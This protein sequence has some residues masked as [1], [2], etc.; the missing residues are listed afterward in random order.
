MILIRYGEIWLKGDNRPLFEKLLADNIRQALNG[1]DFKLARGDGRYYVRDYDEKNESE[2]AKKIEKVFGIHSFSL[3][4]EILKDF[5]VI[6][7][8][9]TEQVLEIAKNTGKRSFKIFCKRSDKRF[10]VGSQGVCMEVGGDVLEAA[11]ELC[12]DV[13]NPQIC[14]YIEIRDTAF[15]Y[16]EIIP[17][18]G[19]MPAG[20]GGRGML[21]LSGGIDSPVAGFMVAKRGLDLN[22]C[23]FDSP[24]YTGERAK[25]KVITLA[26]NLA[27][28]TGKLTLN[29]MYFTE[30]QNAIRAKCPEDMLTLI[31][32]RFMMRIA[33]IKARQ[34]G[35]NCLVTGES[36]GQVASQTVKSMLVTGAVC[37]LPV[38]R[39]LVGM[40]K[41]EIVDRARAIGT[42]ETS[43]LPFE[44]CCTVFVPKHPQTRPELSKIE[45]AEAV[46]PIEELI[47]ECI[48][49]SSAITLKGS[50]LC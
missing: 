35:A 19:G 46:L 37:S 31:M 41:N 9:A 47:E 28:Y 34:C 40:D 10:P 45:A 14:V 24:P 12:V 13:H 39:P 25:G 23:Y 11:P 6:R 5:E 17:G 36:I 18:Q 29:F 42:F 48:E 21:L 8:V 1:Y 30:I 3:A 43:I 22:A 49:K 33:E 4:A 16:S 32:R 7:K 38:F 26:Q 27:G 2:I 15:V 50:S 20:S 44:D